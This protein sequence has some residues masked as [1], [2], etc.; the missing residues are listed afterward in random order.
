MLFMWI[1]LLLKNWKSFFFKKYISTGRQW[2]AFFWDW[3]FNFHN[4]HIRQ[5]FIIIQ[6]TNYLRYCQ[7]TKLNLKISNVKNGL[8][9]IAMLCKSA[10]FS[11]T[12]KTVTISMA[13][14]WPCASLK[15]LNP[16][17]TNYF[18]NILVDVHAQQISIFRFLDALK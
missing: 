12:I 15:E 1:R 17:Q 8:Y 2:F 11:S 14:E 6:H 16:D 10:A 3:I 4:I 9:F 13:N 18:C 5:R 7:K